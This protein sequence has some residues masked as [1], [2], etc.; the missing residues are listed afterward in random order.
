MGRPKL[1]SD[2]ARAAGR[3]PPGVLENPKPIAQRFA[4]AT[5]PR[6]AAPRPA[7]APRAAQPVAA[8]TAN[9]RA[10]KLSRRALQPSLIAGLVVAPVVL[11]SLILGGLWL[12]STG[13]TE[14]APPAA[15]P[16]PQVQISAVL[17]V[18][19][20]IEAFAGEA[21]TIP[22]ALDGTDGVPS[23]S[24]I[25]VRGL[26]QGSNFSE[27]RPYGESEW[28]L[29]PD[30]I[31]DLKL[32]PPAGATGEFKLRIALIAPDDKVI[33]EA[34]TL[35]TVVPGA[36][37]Q[38]AAAQ[39]GAPPAPGTEPAAFEPAGMTGA[40]GPVVGQT[41]GSGAEL[42]E[43][44]AP[45]DAPADSPV[46]TSPD[47][48]EEAMQAAAASSGDAR[49][50][51]VGKAEAGE[52]ESENA[53]GT[54]QPSVF[55]NMR[56]RPASSSAVLGVIAKGA[57]LAVLD[58]QRGWVKVTHPESGKQG[59]IYSGLLVGETKN[60][61][62]VKRVAPAEAAADSESFWGRVGRWLS[63]SEEN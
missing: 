43:E 22:I 2:A 53:L 21:V 60:S 46:E 63:P 34:E 25:A 41:P 29:R 44:L 14:P 8:R 24:V 55:V 32:V 13:D 6:Q 1:K 12:G 17:T 27:G 35:L 48:A 16:E 38:M 47:G 20:R 56:E 45:T 26:P 19:E 61:H 28:N 54:V 37:P 50:N 23:R 36:I 10:P 5:E 39:A 18:P 40:L 62:R 15:A 58:R 51:T 11:L 31:G 57:E 4:Y 9:A 3:Y 42:T 7:D 59:W 49:P 30:Q 33:A 52:D